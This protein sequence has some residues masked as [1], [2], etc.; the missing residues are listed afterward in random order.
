MLICRTPAQLS[1]Q[2]GQYVAHHYNSQEII[3]GVYLV[4]FGAGEPILGRNGLF[5]RHILIAFVAQQPFSSNSRF[6]RTCP[7]GRPFYS[8]SL[9]VESVSSS[10][11]TFGTIFGRLISIRSSLHLCRKYNTTSGMSCAHMLVLLCTEAG[12]QTTASHWY[13]RWDNGGRRRGWLRR[14]RV[15]SIH[16]ASSK[17]ARCGWRV[18]CRANIKEEQVPRIARKQECSRCV[19]FRPERSKG[20]AFV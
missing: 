20:W 12:I 14:F 18:G 10:R 6:L 1:K 5:A 19:R 3:I 4:I 8:A 13:S 9:V 2:A 11:E 16:R 7:D 17:H 15:R